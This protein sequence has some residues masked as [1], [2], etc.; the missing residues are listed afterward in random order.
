M[1][2]FTQEHD[3]QCEARLMPP[4]VNR[5]GLCRCRERALEAELAT[6]VRNEQNC[7]QR[8]QEAG[9]RV[10]AAEARCD[11]LEAALREWQRAHAHAFPV[12]PNALVER[13]DALLSTAPATEPH[14]DDT[15][16]L[17]HSRSCPALYR[18]ACTCCLEWRI[19]LST[20]RTLHAAWRK[21]A[22]EAE[23]ALERSTAP[24]TELRHE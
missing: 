19:K 10:A 12:M 14:Y 5:A 22:E 8:R 3:K 16:T 4:D 24:A 7:W 9:E 18:D 23:A 17:E 13:T 1:A 11:A 21:R 20:E 15:G 2:E 6:A